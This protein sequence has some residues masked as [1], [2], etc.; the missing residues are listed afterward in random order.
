MN[1]YWEVMDYHAYLWMSLSLLGLALLLWIIIPSQR[2]FMLTSGLL[3]APFALTSYFFVPDYWQP[4]RVAVFITGIEDLIFSFANGVIV[5][6]LFFRALPCAVHPTKPNKVNLNRFILS[7]TLGTLSNMSLMRMGAGV[8]E[9]TLL[10]GC[11]F[12]AYFIWTCRGRTLMASFMGGVAFC[13]IYS[14]VFKSSIHL[15]PQISQ[16]FN[17]TGLGGNVVWGIPLGELLWAIFFGSTWPLFCGWVMG[18]HQA[19]GARI[20]EAHI[21]SPA[22]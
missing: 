21:V 5:I 11:M 9:A 2:R 19:L 18:W 20:R 14:L 1:K 4:D 8:M 12:W 22:K 10:T 15:F 17:P 7:L 6:G 13:M 3:S 16:W